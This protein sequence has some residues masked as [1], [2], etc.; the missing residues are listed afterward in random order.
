M[1]R[2]YIPDKQGDL[3]T[4]V[5]QD[6]AL[7]TATPYKYGITPQEAATFNAA[8]QDFK[9]KMDAISGS[10]NL[11][12]IASTHSTSTRYGY[13]LDAG[14][15]SGREFSIGFSSTGIAVNTD[16]TGSD[17]EGI[18]LTSFDPTN[19][20]HDYRLVVSGGIGTLYIDS[21]FFASTP[22]DNSPLV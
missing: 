7:L 8:A 12:I 2:S 18:P 10:A 22:V 19:G 3:L 15:S 4:F 6:A 17:S 13:Y 1:G 16:G 14:D 11:K 21:V 20:Y 9:N 5:L